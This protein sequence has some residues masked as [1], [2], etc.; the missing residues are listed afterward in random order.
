MSIDDNETDAVQR[1]K[2]S[3]ELQSFWKNRNGWPLARGPYIFLADAV[4]LLGKAR[5]GEEWVALSD[6]TSQ[7]AF[8]QR[9]TV[10]EE[11]TDR[12]ATGVIATYTRAREGGP[13]EPISA[14]IWNLDRY[15]PRF[16][17]CL[18]NKAKPYDRSDDEEDGSYIFLLRAE[19]DALIGS[20]P[21]QKLRIED[22]DKL[23][24]FLAALVRTADALQLT[25]DSPAQPSDVYETK[26]RQVAQQIGIEV[27]LSNRLVE[28]AGT[29]LRPPGAG[30]A[31]LKNKSS[32]G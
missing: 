1:V 10:F 23:P 16:Q 20:G 7:K 30:R 4:D 2:V 25:V 27:G 32:L 21:T 26:F 11:L 28:Y 13:Y 24:K 9:G 6:P 12:L 18:V 17:Y 22:V 3:E 5:F 31:A 8:D 29:I 15:R 19:V 14:D